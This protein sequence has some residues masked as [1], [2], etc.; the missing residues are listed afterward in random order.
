MRKIIVLAVLVLAFSFAAMAQDLPKAEVFGGYSYYRA[1]LGNTGT[2]TNKINLNGWNA[3]VTGYF[4]KAVGVTADFSGHYGKPNIGGLDI[5]TKVHNFMFGPTIAA[6]SEKATLFGHALFGGQKFS[7][8]VAGVDLLTDTGFAMALGG[9]VDFNVAKNFAIR[10]AQ[11]DYIYSKHG[12]EHQNNFR[13]SA[14]V[15]LKF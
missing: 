1:D 3:A 12:G 4:S 2:G 9:G 15:V 10:P 5:N 11:A 13:Y 8:K 6:R 14:G 7:T